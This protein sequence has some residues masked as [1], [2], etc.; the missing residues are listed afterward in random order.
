MTRFCSVRLVATTLVVAVAVPAAA[1]HPETPDARICPAPVSTCHAAS[2]DAVI[3]PEACPAGTRCVCVPSCPDCDDCAAEVCVVDGAGH[4]RTACDCE[5]GLGCFDGRCLA[6]FAPVFCCQGDTCP[7]GE[8]CQHDDGRMDRCA[9]SCTAEVWQ[10]DDRLATP[11]GCG[12]GDEPREC[13]CTAS[14][15]LCEDC[16]PP[17][18]I[19]PGLP[20]PYRCDDG[21]ECAAGDRCVCASSCEGCDDCPMQVCVPRSC[22][23]PTCEE[24]LDRATRKIARLVRRTNRCETSEQ[25]VHVGTTTECM[26]TCGEWISRMYEAPFRRALRRADRRI[27]GDYQDDSCRY[28]TSDCVIDGGVCLEGRC[29]DGLQ[30]Q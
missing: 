24:R 25:C 3:G 29:V 30:I 20:T 17:V 15:Q 8:Q 10:C 26:G 1:T 14:C 23:G 19:P 18:C 11:L 16:G 21:N 7:A 2:A 4:C 12:R 13:R 6:G 27:C 22:N 5:P 28:S 9:P